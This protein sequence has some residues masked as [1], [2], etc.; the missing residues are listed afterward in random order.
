MNAPLLE[1][2]PFRLDPVRRL[3]WRDSELIPLKSKAFQTLLVLLENQGRVM[4]KDELMK[5]V[6]PD[7]IVEENTLNK[8]ISAL[9][10]ALGESAGENRYIVTVPGKGYSFVA[11]VREI[12]NGEATEDLVVAT[13]TVSRVITSEEVTET[14]PPFPSTE[15]TEARMLPASRISRRYRWAVA[16]GL[17]IFV[18]ALGIFLYVRRSPEKFAPGPPVNSIAVLPLKTLGMVDAD[19]YLGLGVAD[20]LITKLSSLRQI[21]VRPTSAIIRFANSNQDSVTAAP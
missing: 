16:G 4:D 10:R 19:T 1:F 15:V 2:G 18:A 3:L 8:N 11:G 13:H 21:Q 9:R 12:S 14:T 17:V 6:W 7:A 5:L 20:R